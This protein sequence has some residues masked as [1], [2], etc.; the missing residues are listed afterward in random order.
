METLIVVWW[1]IGWQPAAHLYCQWSIEYRGTRTD[2]LFKGSCINERFKR[3]PGLAVA[4]GRHVKC[5]IVWI[6]GVDIAQQR[7]NGPIVEVNQHGC[8]VRHIVR[9]SHLGDVTLCNL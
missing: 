6:V 1:G 5:P 4:I 9:C 8:R 3:R 2:A 7:A